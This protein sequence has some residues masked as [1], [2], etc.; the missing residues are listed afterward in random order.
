VISVYT[1]SDFA[2]GRKGWKCSVIDTIFA[3]GVRLLFR[4][5]FSSSGQS[6]LTP[7]CLLHNRGYVTSSFAAID[8]N[9]EHP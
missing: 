8:L 7:S 9:A 2:L 4:F 6:H 5:G 1:F 3:M